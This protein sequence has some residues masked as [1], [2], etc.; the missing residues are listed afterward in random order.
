MQIIINFKNDFLRISALTRWWRLLQVT[1]LWVFLNRK[2]RKLWRGNTKRATIIPTATVSTSNSTWADTGSLAITEKNGLFY[3][4]TV[5]KLSTRNVSLNILSSEFCILWNKVGL[6]IEF[7]FLKKKK[8]GLQSPTPA[9]RCPQPRT[10]EHSVPGRGA[11]PGHCTSAFGSW[12]SSWWQGVPIVTPRGGAQTLQT[13]AVSW[14]P[15]WTQR[16]HQDLDKEK[17]SCTHLI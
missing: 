3:Q 11:G 14:R 4:C 8:K 16:A 6:F 9:T 17:G 1:W 12:W 5:R 15:V 13:A 10:T 2:Q 7:R